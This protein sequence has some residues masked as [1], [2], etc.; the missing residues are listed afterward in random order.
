MLTPEENA[1]IQVGTPGNLTNPFHGATTIDDTQAKD[2]KDGRW[3]FNLH[4]KK[5]P[6]GEIRGPVL[7]DEGVRSDVW[8]LA[9]LAIANSQRLRARLSTTF[10]R[11]RTKPKPC[12]TTVSTMSGRP[13]A[14]LLD[15]P[16]GAVPT[17]HSGGVAPER[18]TLVIEQLSNFP[19]SVL[20]FV[21]KGRVTKAD[22]NS[23]LLSA[24]VRALEKQKKSGSTTR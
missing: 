5:F 12:V 24:V 10:V 18:S 4:S 21:C 11:I 16:C 15:Q 7:R 6:V 8:V 14:Q 22:Y 9:V 2:L 1:P 13:H 20:A 19:D 3:Y 17:P 23:V